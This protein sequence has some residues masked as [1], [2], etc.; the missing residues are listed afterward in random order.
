MFNRVPI[1]KLRKGE[2][3]R[4]LL[5]PDWLRVGGIATIEKIKPC[6]NGT[7]I[8]VEVTQVVKVPA[9]TLF[10]PPPIVHDH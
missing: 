1:A 8:W 9:D 10:I 4:A 2:S 3:A 7:H 5:E 6:E